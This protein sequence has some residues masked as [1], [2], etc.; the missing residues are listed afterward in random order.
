MDIVAGPVRQKR[1][2]LPNSIAQIRLPEC[3]T[4]RGSQLDP[5]PRIRTVPTTVESS[6]SSG[7]ILCMAPGSIMDGKKMQLPHFYVDFS[8]ELH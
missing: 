5:A 7:L 4:N 2:E 1:E 8:S 6:L 3:S